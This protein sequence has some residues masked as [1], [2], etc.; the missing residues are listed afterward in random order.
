[1]LCKLANL[2][3]V[4]G[5]EKNQKGLT[6][7]ELFIVIVVIAILI[8]VLLPKLKG[9]FS[10]SKAVATFQKLKEINTAVTAYWSDFG[11]YP[12]DLR[13]LY[14]KDIARQQLDAI[15]PNYINGWVEYLKPPSDPNDHLENAFGGKFYIDSS[16]SVDLN[17]NGRNDIFIIMDNIHQEGLIK[18]D[19]QIDNEPEPST[20]T[21]V[22]S[23]NAIAGNQWPLIQKPGS[24]F[25]YFIIEE[26]TQ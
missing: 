18:L 11:V 10:P 4:K 22:W 9:V 5:N 25:G 2:F 6:L 8:K 12:E 24:G 20:G 1:M 14:N 26:V 21:F 15:N 7:L 17:G 13:A 19:K 3:K 23:M 16:A